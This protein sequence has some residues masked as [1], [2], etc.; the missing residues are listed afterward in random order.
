MHFSSESNIICFKPKKLT[1][2]EIIESNI[3]NNLKTVIDKTIMINNEY[4][5][6]KTINE[7]S[8]INELIGT[9]LAKLI[10]LDAV[11][12]KIGNYNDNL[13]ALSKLFYNQQ[14]DYTYVH[15]Y[16]NKYASANNTSLLKCM[17]S[18]FIYIED[19]MVELVENKEM[20]N[21]ILKLILLDI[22]MGQV[23]RHIF[24]LLI[25][26]NKET[27]QVDLA[28][29]YDF[30]YSYVDNLNTYIYENPFIELKENIFSL[31]AFSLK[32]PQIKEYLDILL[33]TNIQDVLND[34][35]D[36]NNIKIDNKYIDKY[37]YKDRQYTRTLKKF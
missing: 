29:I 25:K 32:Y 34:I 6:S 14:F 8:L 37:I 3:P 31:K 13:Y 36:K 24:N 20:I 12:Y 5:Y 23:D 2:E 21:N 1:D 4:Y 15:N 16:Y 35:E 33:H 7:E 27:K 30:S 17:F 26:I 11:D 10:N 19:S 28:P 22:K 18:P 9:Y